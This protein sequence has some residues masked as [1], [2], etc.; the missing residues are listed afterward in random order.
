M[1][2]P[3]DVLSSILNF[4]GGVILTWD[5]LSVRKIQVEAGSRH[6]QEGLAEAGL[7]DLLTFKGRSVRDETTFQLWASRRSRLWALIGLLVMTAGFLL[8]ILA[9]T[10]KI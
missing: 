8:D 9:K 5:A 7:G 3:L 1:K 2:I 4:A 10:L 6:L